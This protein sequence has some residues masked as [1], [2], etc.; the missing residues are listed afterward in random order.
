MSVVVCVLH[1][2]MSHRNAKYL[3]EVVN[4]HQVYHEVILQTIRGGDV[5]ARGTM[6]PTFTGQYLKEKIEIL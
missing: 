1:V 5:G 3:Y 2:V 6:V 4:Q